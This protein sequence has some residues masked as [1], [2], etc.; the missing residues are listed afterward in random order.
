MHTTVS[1]FSVVTGH[2]SRRWQSALKSLKSKTAIFIAFGI[3]ITMKQI[4][5]ERE[6]NTQRRKMC[7]QPRLK[8]ESEEEATSTT[9]SIARAIRAPVARPP[10][11]CFSTWVCTSNSFCPCYVGF[12]TSCRPAIRWCRSDLRFFFFPRRKDRDSCCTDSGGRSSGKGWI[13]SRGADGRWVPDRDWTDWSRKR[14]RCRWWAPAPLRRPQPPPV[15]S[16]RPARPRTTE[17][18]GRRGRPPRRRRRIVVVVV[19]RR[20]GC[21]RPTPASHREG[22]HRHPKG[23]K[24]GGKDCGSGGGGGSSGSRGGG[25]SATSRELLERITSTESGENV[26]PESLLIETSFF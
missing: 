25:A 17:G 18:E 23:R 1:R 11:G 13:C 3:F 8:F 4:G 12:G 16:F 20:R 7:E 19:R 9:S 6:M 24:T 15:P 10:Q 22:R 26:S 14:R 2:A 21:R 5:S